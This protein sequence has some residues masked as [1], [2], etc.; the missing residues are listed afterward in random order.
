MPAPHCTTLIAHT[1]RP[2]AF[3]T[4][5]PQYMSA[6]FGS[7]TRQKAVFTPP[8]YAFGLPGSF[9]HTKQL[10]TGVKNFKWLYTLSL[11]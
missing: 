5:T 10:L 6:I 9:R 8:W 11:I 2:A 7:H 1:Q 4:A 3:L